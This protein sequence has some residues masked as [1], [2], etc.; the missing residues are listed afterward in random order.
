RQGSSAPSPEGNTE[1]ALY[2]LV[3][4][5]WKKR[6]SNVWLGFHYQKGK[7]VWDPLRVPSKGDFSAN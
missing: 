7:L 5:E 6:L 4:S 2:V 3:V 1:Q